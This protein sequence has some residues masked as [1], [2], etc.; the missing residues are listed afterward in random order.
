MGVLAAVAMSFNQITESFNLFR[1]VLHIKTHRKL[2]GRERTLAFSFG[3][4]IKLH[5]MFLDLHLQPSQAKP[6]QITVFR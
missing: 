2:V 4:D 1:F 3:C 5:L 6:C